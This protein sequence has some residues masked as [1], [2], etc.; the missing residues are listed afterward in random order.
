[1]ILA[2][3][4]IPDPYWGGSILTVCG[5]L[6]LLFFLCIM[7]HEG[8]FKTL[9]SSI[10]FFCLGLFIPG[11]AGSWMVNGEVQAP[12]TGF[13]RGF[14]HRIYSEDG[15]SSMYFKEYYYDHGHEPV[16][17]DSYADENGFLE[18]DGIYY[19][20]DKPVFAM[21]DPL[22]DSWHVPVWF[23][24]PSSF[25]WVPGLITLLCGIRVFFS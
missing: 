24:H 11:W 23:F 2:Q 19:E 13:S 15:T 25:I 4:D 7:G 3:T 14:E 5:I 16:K 1:M 20:K 6:Y 12:E 17:K 21:H 8:I 22:S 18:H 10:T 9:C